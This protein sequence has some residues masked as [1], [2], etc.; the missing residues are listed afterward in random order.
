MFLPLQCSKCWHT[1]PPA[2]SSLSAP[3]SRCRPGRWPTE[4]SLKPM[5]EQVFSTFSISSAFT[6]HDETIHA[7]EPD[8][9][10]QPFDKARFKPRHMRSRAPNA[11]HFSLGGSVEMARRW[12][13]SVEP[14]V[15][16]GS[17]DVSVLGTMQSVNSRPSR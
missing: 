11:L 16:C 1:S 3:Q 15:P 17:V 9:S 14:P 7:L 13:R 6:Q 12:S 5:Q 4:L 8:R 10:D 2:R